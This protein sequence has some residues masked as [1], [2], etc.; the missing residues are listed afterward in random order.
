MSSGT[1]NPFPSNSFNNSSSLKTSSSEIWFSVWI[2]SISLSKSCKDLSWLKSVTFIE[3]EE[4]VSW[5]SFWSCFSI[6]SVSDWVASLS[7]GFSFKISSKSAVTWSSSTS[8]SWSGVS[9][10]GSGAGVSTTGSGAGVSITG[11]GAGVSTTGSGAGVS[12]TGSGA[13][14]STTGSG[15]GSVLILGVGATCEF[16]S[17]SEAFCGAWEGISWLGNCVWVCCPLDW[18]IKSL[19]FWI[20]WAWWESTVAFWISKPAAFGCPP[21]PN[22]EAIIVASKSSEVIR[23]EPWSTLFGLS[24]NNKTK[25]ASW[26]FD[27]SSSI[28]SPL[29]SFLASKYWTLILKTGHYKNNYKRQYLT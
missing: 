1:S 22:W 29:S 23:I 27:K 14:V 26:A 11:S 19:N 3:S 7:S 10:T 28:M 15:A 17:C 2:S 4:S 9:I 8:W 24:S 5:I 20:I 21:P 18:F 13:G 16:E 12:T 25:S 6:S